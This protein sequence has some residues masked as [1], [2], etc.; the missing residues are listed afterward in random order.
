MFKNFISSSPTVRKITR[1]IGEQRFREIRTKLREAYSHLPL[2]QFCIVPGKKCWKVK[3]KIVL[4]SYGGT[5]YDPI[6]IAIKTAL[7]T[8]TFPK[9]MHI[10]SKGDSTNV[11]ISRKIK[12]SWTPDVSDVPCII[13]LRQV[14]ISLDFYKN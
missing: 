6:S 5:F 2:E 9:I 4:L 3:V 11:K 8:S 12:D 10:S 7:M 1:R 14:C 13:T